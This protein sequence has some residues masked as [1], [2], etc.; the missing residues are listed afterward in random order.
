MVKPWVFLSGHTRHCS[1]SLCWNPPGDTHAQSEP[2]PGKE[3]VTKGTM[4]LWDA[5]IHHA[6]GLLLFV[7]QITIRSCII[8]LWQVLRGQHNPRH[9]SIWPS[10]NKE[11]VEL[12][13]HQQGWWAVLEM[14][15][16]DRTLFVFSHTHA[17][18][19]CYHHPVCLNHTQLLGVTNTCHS[20]TH[21]WV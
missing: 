12:W 14:R 1:M 20:I 17:Y 4:S 7:N 21:K 15:L 11:C 3:E 19:Q 5:G 2:D 9:L 13:Q 8:L 16:S 6:R 18:T 10:R